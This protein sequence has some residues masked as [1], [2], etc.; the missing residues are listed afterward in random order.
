VRPVFDK[1]VTLSLGRYICLKLGHAFF[2]SGI[3]ML[4]IGHLLFESLRMIA[5][6]LKPLAHDRRRTVLVNRAF[7]EVEK[8]HSDFRG[9]TEKR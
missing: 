7:N 6:E 8:S 5:N 9:L 2:K 3:L 1:L 4:K